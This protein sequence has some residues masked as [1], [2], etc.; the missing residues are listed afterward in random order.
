[1]VTSVFPDVGPL[2]GVMDSTCGAGGTYVKPP[3]LVAA[4]PSGLATTTLTEASTG[5]SAC[6]GVV[7]VIVVELETL[8]FVAATPP[9]FT[10]APETKFAPLMVTFVPPASGPTFGATEVIDGVCTAAGL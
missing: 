4:C 5:V 1:M 9:N 6:G 10:V 2:L 8:T 7:A 3:L